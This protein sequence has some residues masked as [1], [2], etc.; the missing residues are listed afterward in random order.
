MRAFSYAC[1]LSVTRGKMA[2]TPF[3]PPYPKNPMLHANITALYFIERELS[4]IEVLHCRNRIFDLCGSCDLDLDPMTFI[5]E[6]DPYSLETYRMCENKLHTF[7]VSKD[8]IWQ[9]DR[10]TDRHTDRQT[11]G[12]V[13]NNI[14][15]RFAGGQKFH[16]KTISGAQ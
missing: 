6:L 12:Q 13:R 1:S 15:H 8:I 3:D 4:S 11:D 14:P 16:E 7:T 5:C 9:T 10:H 2:V